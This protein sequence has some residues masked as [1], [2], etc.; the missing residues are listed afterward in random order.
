MEC[1]KEEC[2]MKRI[3][4]VTSDNQAK[5]T[6]ISDSFNCTQVILEAIR[7]IS[8]VVMCFIDN[9][10]EIIINNAPSLGRHNK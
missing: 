2:T 1:T 9:F 7:K 8:S 5:L 4:T 6:V 3:L 10:L